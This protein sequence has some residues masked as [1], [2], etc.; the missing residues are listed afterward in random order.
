MSSTMALL[1]ADNMSA[2]FFNLF[3]TDFIMMT[4]SNIFFGNKLWN[5]KIVHKDSWLGVNLAQ[6]S[7]KM[8]IILPNFSFFPVKIERN[9]FYFNFQYSRK[10]SLP[11]IFFFFFKRRY[12]RTN[13]QLYC[14]F[15]L[16]D[17]FIRNFQMDS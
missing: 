13:V 10:N 9:D 7:P 14:F 15:Y 12:F 11:F 1:Q 5:R 17:I 3:W 4:V 6:T 8:D 16:P 2:I